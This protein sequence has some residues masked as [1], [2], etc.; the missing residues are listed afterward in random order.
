MYGEGAV[1]D[2]M[3]QKWLAKFRAGDFSLGNAPRSGRSGE[4]DGDQIKTLFENNQHYT[5]WKIAKILKTS[6]SIS[7]LV[8]MKNVSF[9]LQK[10][11]PTQTFWPT[12]CQVSLTC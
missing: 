12:Q 5:T 2:Q 1:T 6:K 7:L 11:K 4:V 8:K 9:I 10:K 3:Y